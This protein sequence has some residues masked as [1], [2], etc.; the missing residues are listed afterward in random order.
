MLYSN[1]RGNFMIIKY[2]GEKVRIIGV[3]HEDVSIENK[4]FQVPKQYKIADLRSN[5]SEYVYPSDLEYR[6]K[7]I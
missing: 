3:I 7:D 1:N 2:K 5:W 6:N 4:T